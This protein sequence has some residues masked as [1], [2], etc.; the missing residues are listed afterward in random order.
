[1][2]PRGHPQRHIARADDKHRRAR[3]RSHNQTRDDASGDPRNSEAAM[4]RIVLTGG[5]GAGKTVISARIAQLRPQR[6]IKVPEAATQVYNMLQTRWDRLEVEGRRDIQRRIYRLQREQED[7]L[8]KLHPDRVL[9]LDRGTVD[10][11]AYWPD[12]PAAYWTDLATTEDAELARYDAV[13]WLE[14]C[15]ALGLYD[16]DAS[17]AVRFEDAAGAIASGELLKR[18]WARHPRLRFVPACAELDQKVAAVLRELDA[19]S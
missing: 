8:A 3:D 1:L 5:P 13:I 2:E 10:G 6:Y 19:L 11:S 14:S 18:L 4:K 15:A 17:N 16:A 9:L 12:G 7:R